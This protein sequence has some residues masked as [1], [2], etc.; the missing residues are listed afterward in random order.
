[1]SCAITRNYITS[2]TIGLR[3]I[4]AFRDMT[5]DLMKDVLKQLSLASRDVTIDDDADNRPKANVSTKSALL[6]FTFAVQQMC[7][8]GVA[9]GE[10]L[11]VG[12][13]HVRA[14]QFFN[15][16]MQV[17]KSGSTDTD[18]DIDLPVLGSTTQQN[19][20]SFRKFDDD[21]VTTFKSKTSAD[22]FTPIYASIR[23]DVAVIAWGDLDPALEFEEIAWRVAPLGD[24]IHR[25]DRQRIQKALM[26]ATKHKG[27]SFLEQNKNDGDGRK[28]YFDLKEYISVPASL[29]QVGVEPQA[30]GSPQG[31]ET[32]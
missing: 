9:T 11:V 2:E 25:R 31:F 15:E 3:T 32:R 26:D 17:K 12:I 8:R 19:S 29:F 7:H 4:A 27:K 24:T 28:S 10:P 13:N 20:T 6:T 16:A 30:F 14:K 1:M 5:S 23:D 18:A 22:G 21:V